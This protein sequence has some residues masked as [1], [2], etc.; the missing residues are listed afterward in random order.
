MLSTLLMR[1]ASSLLSALLGG[2]GVFCVIYSFAV[3]S[4]APDA[5]ILLGSALAITYFSDR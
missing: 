3:P 1:W 5:L 4:V 2:S